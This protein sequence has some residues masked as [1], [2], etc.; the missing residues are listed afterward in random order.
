MSVSNLKSRWQADETI[1]NAWISIPNSWTAEIVAHAGFDTMTIDTQ[2]GLATD[3]STILPMLQ[4]ILATGT[5]SFVR[6]PDHNAAYIMRMLDAGAGGLICPMVNNRHEAEEF[7]KNCHYPPLG[8]R[9]F[10]PVRAGELYKGDYFKDAADTFLTMVM[11]ETADGVKNLDEIAATPHLDGLYVGPW[12]LSLAMDFNTLA[13]F[14]SP[15]LLK[16][17]DKILNAAAKHGKTAGIHCNSPETAR[18]MSEMGFRFVT[19]FSDSSGLSNAANEAL[20]EFKSN[21]SP[22]TNGY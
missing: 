10:G 20:K 19:P 18:Q 6:L 1:V 15:D 7:V 4:A 11:I 8:Y 21:R 17:L 9:S 14:Q 2:H 13:D 16:L 3:L 5:V 22:E 12:D